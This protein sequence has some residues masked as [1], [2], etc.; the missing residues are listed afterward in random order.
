MN[1]AILVREVNLEKNTTSYNKVERDKAIELIIPQRP[2]QK[3]LQE[4]KKLHENNQH[5]KND[6]EEAAGYDALV[7]KVISQ[8][9]DT[10]K[11]QIEVGEI[12]IITRKSDLKSLNDKGSYY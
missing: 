4:I 1:N 10:K 12:Q 2:V 11:K 6:D 8:V 9:A 7:S 5:Y 3:A